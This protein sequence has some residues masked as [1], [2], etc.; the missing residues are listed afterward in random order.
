MPEL[1][2]VESAEELARTAAERLIAVIVEAVSSRGRAVLALSGGSTPKA[3]YASLAQHPELPWD[4]VDLCFGDERCV[5]PDDPQSNAR[6]VHDALTRSSFVPP[7]R[8]HRMRGELA[9][10]A[11]AA[12]YERVLRELFVDAALPRFDLVLLGLGAD[13]HTASLFPG[14]RALAERDRWVA[15]NWVEPLRSTRLTLTFP[16][17]NA[18]RAVLFLIAGADKARAVHSVLEASPPLE[19]IPATGVRPVAGSLTFMLDRA[20]TSM[21]GSG[22]VSSRTG[23]AR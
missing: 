4:K 22:L 1:C 16:V 3:V 23:P 8:V 14:S 12:D 19:D 11:A 13:G 21:L 18:A 9:P 6:M 7:Q 20:S 15:A 10:E 5:P 17:I 2:V